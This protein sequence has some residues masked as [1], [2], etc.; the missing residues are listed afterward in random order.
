VDLARHEELLAGLLLARDP[1][2]FLA[3]LAP[4]ERAGLARLDPAGLRLTRLLV[5][6]LRFERLLHGSRAAAEWFAS[7]PEGFT[8][9]FKAYHHEVPP[10]CGFPPEEAQAFA[11]W[12][13]A[14]AAG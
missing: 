12:R 2:A 11:A 8:R 1:E 4:D 5:A 13:A 9:A 6:R 3:T 14:H 10:R 7:D